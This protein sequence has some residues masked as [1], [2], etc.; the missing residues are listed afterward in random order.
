[1]LRSRA[2]AE[3]SPKTGA[4]WTFVEVYRLCY[5]ELPLMQWLPFI[6]LLYEVFDNPVQPDQLTNI[7]NMIALVTALL[8]NVMLAAPLSLD[9]DRLQSVNDRFGAGGQNHQAFLHLGTLDFS[10]MSIDDL[11]GLFSNRLLYFYSLA[12]SFLSAT[13]LAVLVSVVVY[14][15][16]ALDSPEAEVAYVDWWRRCGRWLLLLQMA[17][18]VAGIATCYLFFYVMVDI[19]FPNWWWDHG[20]DPRS[21]G[22]AL[23]D[24][25]DASAFS[26][27]VQLLL[28]YVTLG[29]VAGLLSY[30]SASKYLFRHVY[31]QTLR[32]KNHH[33]G[34][35][36]KNSAAAGL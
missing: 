4:P 16:S 7:W 19:T 31:R 20:R 33:H 11:G 22:T 28:V 3:L 10:G 1:M 24:V 29:A 18:A 5:S 36:G 15:S 26:T 32:E 13:L 9:Y 25:L 6:N 8:L 34:A 23:T 30:G 12:T 14:G 27:G 21:I 35:G 2:D 17:S